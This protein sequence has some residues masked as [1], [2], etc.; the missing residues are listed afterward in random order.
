MMNN[1]SKKSRNKI[2]VPR[3]NSSCQV[4]ALLKN[5]CHAKMN[6]ASKSTKIKIRFTRINSSCQV[7]ASRMNELLPRNDEQR[8]IK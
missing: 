7:T 4:T 2:R 6:N 3:I 8:L 5:C 1:A